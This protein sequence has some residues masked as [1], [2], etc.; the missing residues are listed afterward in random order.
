MNLPVVA[1]RDETELRRIA[2]HLPHALLI[3]AEEGLE[4]DQVLEWLAAH[5]PSELIHIAPLEKKT[6]ISVEQIRDL[7]HSVRTQPTIRRV[8][9]IAEAQ[10]MTEAASNALLKLLEEPGQGT[11]FILATPD[12]ELLLPTIRS[13]CQSLTLHRTPPAQD[14]AQAAV[15]AAGRP[16]LIRELSR[17]P[18][19]FSEYRQFATD[20]KQL[21]GGG[22]TYATLCTL[23][24]YMNDRQKALRLIDV[25]VHMIRF[26]MTANGCDERVLALLER[27]EQAET[28]LK[29]NGNV[30]LALLQLVN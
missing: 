8:I 15:L 24:G 30:R 4:S 14:A 13:R 9:I 27:A 1:L 20:A 23:H 21:L 10:L 26:Q 2:E 28:A 29:G 6:T 5:R 3:I 7:Q 22:D 19:R 12:E 17:Q 16:R 11:H 25:L 18:K